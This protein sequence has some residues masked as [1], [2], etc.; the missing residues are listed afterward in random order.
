MNSE[1]ANWGMKNK[2]K[3]FY[4]ILYNLNF[5]TLFKDV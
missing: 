5:K 2:L 1:N 3:T 4:F